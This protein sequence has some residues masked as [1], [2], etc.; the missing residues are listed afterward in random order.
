MRLFTLFALLI[1]AVPAE[2]GGRCR[3]G[4]G[5][6]GVFHRRPASCSSASAY[7]PSAG[8]CGS[9]S[10]ASAPQSSA[11]QHVQTLPMPTQVAPANAGGNC[12]GGVCIR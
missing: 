6:G 10:S 9:C 1:L 8:S 2:A 11:P 5:G 12:F 7:T 4:R 3:G